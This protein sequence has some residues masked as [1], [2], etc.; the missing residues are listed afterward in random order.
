M[1]NIGLGDA[2][3]RVESVLKSLHQSHFKFLFEFG[4]LMIVSDFQTNRKR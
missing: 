2:W 4:K 3:T 1:V